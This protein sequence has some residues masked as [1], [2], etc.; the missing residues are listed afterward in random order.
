MEAELGLEDSCIQRA[1]RIY[2]L[3]ALSSLL[4]RGKQAKDLLEE[5][6]PARRWLSLGVL[7]LMTTEHGLNA[8]SRVASMV[9]KSTVGLLKGSF[10]K[11]GEKDRHSPL[12]GM[13][14]RLGPFFIV[15]WNSI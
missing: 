11:D 2:I 1:R 5:Q 8:Y 13:C 9:Q 6:W 7:P 12:L 15:T 4:F 3:L 10:S 14:F